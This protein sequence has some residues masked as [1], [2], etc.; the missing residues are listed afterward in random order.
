MSRAGW[1]AIVLFCVATCSCMQAQEAGW[2]FAV[3]GDSRNCGDLVMPSIA[4][5]ATRHD[6]QFYWHLG[7]LRA[8]YDFDQDMLA[9]GAK[10][11]EKRSMSISD[12]QRT[13]WDDFIQRQ[14]AP[15][16]KMP[17]FVGIGNHE[18][19]PPKDRNQFLI[20]FADWLDSPALRQQRLAD[21]PTDHRLHTYFHWVER[22]VD[23]IYLDNVSPDQFAVE[24]VAWFER[25]LKHDR[26]DAGIKTV[27]VGTHVPLPDG[28]SFSHSM[29]D[30]PAGEQSGRRVYQDLLALRNEAHKHVYVLSSHSHFF[31][32]GIYDSDYLRAHGGVLPGWIAGTAGAVRYPLPPT[33]D[34]AQAAKTNVYGYLLGAVAPD[35]TIKF[36]FQE[37]KES[38]V[39][40]GVA[41][42]YAPEAVHECY[43]GNSAAR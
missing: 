25:V 18:L 4:A 21:D 33:A 20:Q 37:V 19:A 39:P 6:A 2:R 32:A 14:I 22:G 34:R 11:G 41:S 29:N 5:S 16:G 23:F 8:M 1:R 38:D 28:L 9:R 10:P 26:E 42:Q 36:E 31:M 40:A 13:A 3:S 7:D 27:V 12:Y 24:Q 43:A 15:F 35:G 30:W 17:V